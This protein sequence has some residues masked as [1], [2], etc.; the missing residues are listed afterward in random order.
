ML[1]IAGV[2][3]AILVFTGLPEWWDGQYPILRVFLFFAF[4][5]IVSLLVA[6]KRRTKSN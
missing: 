5:G 6:L 3:L 4:G 2:L 1:A